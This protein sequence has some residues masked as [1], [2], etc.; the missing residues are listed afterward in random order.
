MS[1]ATYC[2]R[3]QAKIKALELG[4]VQFREKL[5]NL[6]QYQFED[7][8]YISTMELFQAV[9]NMPLQGAVYNVAPNLLSNHINQLDD[10]K[11]PIGARHG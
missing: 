6:K 4:S 1:N 3:L 2:K 8:T 5:M 10:F 11:K 7:C 9:L